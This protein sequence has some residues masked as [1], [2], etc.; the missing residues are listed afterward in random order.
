MP[1]LSIKA[2]IAFIAERWLRFCDPLR[3]HVTSPSPKKALSRPQ[4]RQTARAGRAQYKNAKSLSQNAIQ[5]PNSAL[6]GRMR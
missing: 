2:E 6:K 4:A 5:S 3:C 1:Q